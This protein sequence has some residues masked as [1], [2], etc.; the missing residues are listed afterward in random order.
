MKAEK[1]E[2]GGPGPETRPARTPR[3]APPPP[4]LSFAVCLLLFLAAFGVRLL[5]LGDA[6]LEAGKVQ[7][8]VTDNYKHMARLLAE[9]G[10]GGFFGGS[11][12]LADPDTLGHPPGYPV[13]IALVRGAGGRSDR[14]LQL[15]QAGADSLAAVLVF[16]IAVELLPSGAAALA[17]LLVALAPQ[18]AWNSV[19]LLPDTLAVLP[20]LAAVYLVARALKRPRLAAFFAAGALVGVSCW[21][22]ANALL[23]APVL[24]AAVFLLSEKRSRTRDA[25]AL[26]AGAVLFVAPLTLRNAVAFG[27]FIPVSLGAGQTLLEGIADYDR[28]NRFGIP[29]TDLGIMRQ[30][31]EAFARPDYAETLFGP[32]AVARERRRL[33]R[34]R[35]V[36]F[37]HPLWFASVMARRAASMLRLE[38]AR[39]VSTRPPVTHAPEPAAGARPA[40]SASP[41]ELSAAGGRLLSPSASAALEGGGAALRLTGDDSKDAAQFASAPAP[42][43]AA[44]DYLFEVGLAVERGRMSVGVTDESGR[45]TLAATIIEASEG[46]RPAGGGAPV[47]QSV[48]IPFVSAGAGPVRLAF[49]NAPSDPPRPVVRVAGARLFAL[50]PASQAWTRYPRLAVAAAQ[51]LFITA[52]MLP[53]ALAGVV[54]LAREKKWRALV[55]LLAVPVY[56]LC[57]QS[58]LHTEYRYVLAVHYFLFVAAAVSLWRA[59]HILRRGAR[60]VGARRKT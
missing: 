27:A 28:A 2:P 55:L 18:F 16:L 4:G 6:Q 1:G 25:L 59:G 50:G 60:A 8:A 37:K 15:V 54:L 53:L 47:F 41:A 5:M 3:P 7:T 43:G 48:K 33:A 10:V 32:D 34:G 20:V 42:A 49:F 46:A 11:P 26:V 39:T 51:K 23:L 17:G 58:A 29:A 36:I 21:L 13:L 22:R 31:A 44:T 52:V 12:A 19:L 45:E 57:A 40:W 38:R 56:Y 9:G 35:E 24:A 14:A 30:E